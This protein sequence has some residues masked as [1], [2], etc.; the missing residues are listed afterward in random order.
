MNS[1]AS[2]TY[3]RKVIDSAKRQFGVELDISEVQAALNHLAGYGG[4]KTL[5]LQDGREVWLINT[6]Q[7]N[8][9]LHILVT[10][11]PV[12]TVVY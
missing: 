12:L 7:D 3:A 10:M 8:E 5:R 1:I 11:G 2:A 9:Q 4:T 6:D